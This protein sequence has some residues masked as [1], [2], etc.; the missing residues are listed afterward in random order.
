LHLRL[1]DV[2]V[3]NCSSL[4]SCD[5]IFTVIMLLP[6]SGTGI[7]I[8]QAKV[9]AVAVSWEHIGLGARSQRT[10]Q[11]TIARGALNLHPVHPTPAVEK[12]VQNVQQF[13]LAQ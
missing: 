8:S 3:I 4:F 10:E 9:I 2:Q 6:S 1:G 7:R 11:G 12:K 5:G 13:A